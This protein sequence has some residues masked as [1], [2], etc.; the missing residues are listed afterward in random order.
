M[1]GHVR[2]RGNAWYVVV[3][4]PR[5]P[6]T[7]K[8][9]QKWH[10]GFRTK[11]EADKALTEIL[12]RLDRGTYV[13]PTKQT[14]GDY[15]DLF[16][17]TVE[18]EVRPTTYANYKSLI[19]KTIAPELGPIPLQALTAAHLDA[20]YADLL[21]SGR[22]IGKGGLSPAT[23][24]YVH[25]IIR[26]ALQ[27]ALRRDLVTRNVAE[28]ATPPR[29]PRPQVR[30]WSAREVRQ[31]LDHVRDDR[32]YALWVLACTTGCGE[33]RCSDCA[34]RTSTSKRPDSRSCAR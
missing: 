21:T 8:R 1:R 11:R 5:D 13:A 17:K 34:G 26:K 27:A 15:L 23:V 33:G 31:F 30:T 20:F 12:S 22:R 6:R 24:R 4:L 9:Q 16:L 29:V 18:R 14:F 3:D 25:S 7:G 10:S 19:D 28:A 2:K 32:L